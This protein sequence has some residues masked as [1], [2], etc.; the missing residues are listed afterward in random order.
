MM[1]KIYETQIKTTPVGWT[2]PRCGGGVAPGINRCPC[3]SIPVTSPL[4]P[5]HIPVSWRYTDTTMET[6]DCLLAAFFRAN[7]R[8]TAAFISCS[9]SRCSPR[10]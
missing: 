6:D 1:K 9:C 10:F 4:K 8:E 2:C 7:P 5:W 3:V